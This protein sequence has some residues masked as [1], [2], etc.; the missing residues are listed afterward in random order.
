MN[1]RKRGEGRAALAG[2]YFGGGTVKLDLLESS[3][4]THPANQNSSCTTNVYSTKG[5]TNPARC[6]H[7][8]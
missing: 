2:N 3:S 4:G 8:R 1:T 6:G 7:T 5:S